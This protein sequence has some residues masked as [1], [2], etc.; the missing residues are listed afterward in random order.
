ML[1]ATG[2]LL[3][4]WLGMLYDF[5]RFALY[6]GWRQNMRDTSVRNYSAVRVYHS[7]EKS[8]TL[9][10]RNPSAG[11]QASLILKRIIDEACSSGT[12]GYHDRVA[13][14]VLKQ[15]SSQI[16]DA[17]EGKR[18]SQ[19][20]DAFSERA[21]N[22]GGIRTVGKNFFEKSELSD[23]E[24]FFMSRYSLR[25]FCD[26]R[27]ESEVMQRAIRLAMKSP[28]VCNRQAWHV[29]DLDCPDLVKGA[30]SLQN[31]N[32]GFG[33]K[34]NRLL[35]VTSDLKAFFSS[36]ERY[37]H[38]IDGGLF[39]MSL[40]LALHSLGVASCCLNWS[41]DARTDIK[42]RK[43]LPIAP[44]HTIIMFLAVGYPQESNK[45]CE[46]P[47]RPIDEVYTVLKGSN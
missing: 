44:E 5:I 47:R 32:R 24:A 46:S 19:E 30:L 18:L 7:L 40:V 17:G 43:I 45:V 26:R 23:P 11:W 3:F 9:T 29:Y 8:L 16:A 1:R 21:I 38:W 28:S 13:L 27:I 20:L 39:S 22:V 4:C 12:Y 41:Q 34:I 42:L 31:G 33:H 37:Q 36:K 35:I 14:S 2:R 25:E 15:F 6:S 10:D